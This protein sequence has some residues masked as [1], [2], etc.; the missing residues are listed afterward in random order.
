MGTKFEFTLN[1]HD[2]FQKQKE[3]QVPSIE[4]RGIEE[5][6]KQADSCYE[7]GGKVMNAPT[8]RE[9]AEKFESI[10]GKG[11]SVGDDK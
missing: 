11:L 9:M 1:L 5:I 3:C 8:N 7:Y 4:K 10:C 6:S 2:V